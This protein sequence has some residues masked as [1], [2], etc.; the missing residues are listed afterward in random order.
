MTPVCNF[1]ADA[2]RA[3]LA[4]F[5]DRFLS[6]GDL[7]LAPAL[8]SSKLRISGFP[9]HGGKGIQAAIALATTWRLAFP[10]MRNVAEAMVIEGERAMTHFLFEGSHSKA[11][12]GISATGRRVQM[13]GA[14][15]FVFENDQIVEWRY[16]EDRLSLAAGL[17]LQAAE[18]ESPEWPFSRIVQGKE[19]NHV[20]G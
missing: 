19:T 12:C 1:G 16:V 13:R 5:Y 11:F 15:L 3:V 8:F 7:Q 17:G 9:L 18:F 4:Q 10:D 14:D 20:L 2:K 6:A